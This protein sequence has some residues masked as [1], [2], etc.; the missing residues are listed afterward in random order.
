MSPSAIAPDIYAQQNVTVPSEYSLQLAP[1][2]CK[3]LSQQR[4]MCIL[5]SQWC[6]VFQLN[7]VTDSYDPVHIREITFGPGKHIVTIELPCLYLGK[8]RNAETLSLT[9]RIV[10]IVYDPDSS[11]PIAISFKAAEIKGRRKKK[12]QSQPLEE[13]IF[14]V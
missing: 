12:Q 4:L 14:A 1:A 9:R 3:P 13:A 11:V 6:N 7:R 5:T 8:H 10:Q 2:G